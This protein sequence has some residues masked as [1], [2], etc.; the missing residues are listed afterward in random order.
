MEFT[1]RVLEALRGLG[2]T[3]YETRAY[4][5]LVVHGSLS[6]SDVSRYARIPYSKVYSVL[7]RL[8]E[9][10]WI[11][12]RRGRPTTYYARPPSEVLRVEKLRRESQFMEYERSI[13]EELQPVYEREGGGERPNIWIIRGGESV[14][15][16]IRD[17]VGRAKSELLLALPSLPID[18]SALLVPSL[19]HMKN[20]GVSVRLLTTEDA[21]SQFTSVKNVVETRVLDGM[22]GG[23]VI[24]DGKEAVL[25]LGGRE[26][27]PP[28]AI[29]SDHIGLAQVA[30]VYFEHLWSLA[31]EITK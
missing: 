24:V 13:L 28:L 9:K 21:L 25:I 20:L 26:L 30:R 5:A 8:E 19:L 12:A 16:R 31:R 29:W 23:G 6:A 18:F 3:E 14:M 27:G 15:A 7:E 1:E 17:A 2:L 11:E 4:L 10:G 22:L